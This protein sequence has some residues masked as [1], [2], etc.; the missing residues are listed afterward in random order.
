MGGLGSGNW[1]RQ[2]R[3][4]VEDC[5]PLS[6]QGLRRADLVRGGNFIL[7]WG[8]RLVLCGTLTVSAADRRVLQL[9]Q[10]SA[11]AAPFGGQGVAL[12][13]TALH[14][15]GCR[16]WFLCPDCGGRAGKLFLPP[17]G[18]WFACRACHGLTYL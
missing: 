10:S 5:V 6:I 3:T 2:A 17:G 9:V 4:P 7:K 1:N 11:S 8:D 12:V 18:H 13:S 15:G 14:F 16:W